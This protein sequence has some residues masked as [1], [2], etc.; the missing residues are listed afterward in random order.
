[1]GFFFFLNFILLE[2]NAYSGVIL[3]DIYIFYTFLDAGDVFLFTNKDVYT[4]RSSFIYM[5]I[6]NTSFVGYLKRT[7]MT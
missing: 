3:R 4:L 2:S 5:D 1:M 7:E 6:Y